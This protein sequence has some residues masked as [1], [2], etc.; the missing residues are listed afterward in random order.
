MP[1]GTQSISGEITRP[2]SA[3]L[4]TN[5]NSTRKGFGLTTAAAEV[6]R[7][8]AAEAAPGLSWANYWQQRLAGLPRI[9]T[10]DQIQITQYQAG[11]G[12][13]QAVARFPLVIGPQTYLTGN[14]TRAHLDA[15]RAY[16]PDAIFLAYQ[17]PFEDVLPLNT[18]PGYDA[19]RPLRSIESAY[20]HDARGN[21]LLVTELSGTR[22]MFDPRSP[23]V[24]A[25]I[26]GAVAAVL[27]AY[28]HD[29]IFF[30]NY[31]L[32]NAM[33]L[34]TNGN[35]FTGAP[36]Q[37]WSEADYASKLGAM[38]TLAEEI[39]AA[40]PG[41]LLIANSANVFPAFNG[42]LVEGS[43]Q[44][45]RMPVQATELPGRAQPFIPLF[46]DTPVSGPDDPII[47]AHRT[48]V[49]ALGG[50]YGVSVGNQNI[51]WPTAF[52]NCTQVANPTQLDADADGD[53]YGNPC[54]ADLNNSALVTTADFGV[55]RTALNSNAALSPVTAAS[56][57][58][59]SG[60]VTAADLGLLRAQLNTPPGPSALRP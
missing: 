19:L 28:P 9:F 16:N 48:Q 31:G 7:L 23:T 37:I 60:T 38:L 5:N 6:H 58:N 56:D 51:L 20:M 45:Y 22:G 41:A 2:E 46:Q 49:H 57:L 52:D 8:A 4:Q 32:K 35:Q 33:L 26:L 47:A 12:Q 55:L 14:P 29:G 43:S 17:I 40:W 36:G 50:W 13:E 27:E 54:D 44:F 42:E 39:R 3:G 21:R 30:D 1:A 34:D 53:G 59:G 24:R 18:G 15:I 25:A 10:I 11:D